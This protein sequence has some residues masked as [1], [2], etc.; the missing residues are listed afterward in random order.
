MLIVD[1]QQISDTA[2]T[3]AELLQTSSCLSALNSNQSGRFKI[4]KNWFFTIDNA[5]NKT[6]VIDYYSKLWHHVKFNGTLGGD[7]QKGGIYLFFLSDQ[8]TN[9]PTIYYNCKIGYHDN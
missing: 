2:P 4:L 7:I 3:T 5:K 9:T 1:N 8:P 6:R